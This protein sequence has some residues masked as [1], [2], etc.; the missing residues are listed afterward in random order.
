MQHWNDIFPGRMLNLSYEELVGDS[1]RQARRILA[2][3]GLGA[4]DGLTDVTANRTSVSTESRS[5]VRQ[6]IHQRNI[7]GWRRYAKQLAPLERMLQRHQ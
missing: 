4:R 2:Y 6:P 7:G 5:Q 1:E 3:C